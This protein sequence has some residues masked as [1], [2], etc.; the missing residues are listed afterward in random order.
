MPKEAPNSKKK[1]L[2]LIAVVILALVLVA[3]GVRHSIA[4][5][6][7]AETYNNA[8]QLF[9]LGRYTEARQL[10]AGLSSYQDAEARV[11][12][13]DYRS[14][15]KLKDA[16]LY[17]DAAAAFTALGNYADAP[18]MAAACAA[19]LEDR[20][21]ASADA[22]FAAGEYQKALLAYM[23]IGGTGRSAD[24]IR[25]CDYQLT[26]QRLETVTPPEA[27][28]ELETWSGYGDSA[29]R[30]AALQE[31]PYFLRQEYAG[32][33]VHDILT[34]GTYEQDNDLENGPEP[35]EWLVLEDT[36][37]VLTLISRYCLFFQPYDADNNEVT[38]ETCGL[39][40]YLNDEFFTT[41]F[42]SREAGII[43]DT[44]V[45]TPDNRFRKM[46]GGNDTVDKVYVLSY[47]EASTLF[48][49]RLARLCDTT[50]YALTQRGGH[51]PKDY[52]PTRDAWWLRT[53]GWNYQYAVYVHQDGRLVDYD[54]CQVYATCCAVRPVIRINTVG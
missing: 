12:E 26:L 4:P 51:I 21:Y 28:A 49:D 16:E 22:L 50:P 54:S 39:R 47:Q 38:W 43:E 44:S 45:H 34:L 7:N 41:A 46:P 24:G 18:E 23:A 36:D 15:M 40:R 53:T 3:A 8:L 25:A 35:I 30:I 17:T 52:H 2:W 5:D 20:A 13:C 37:G 31:S 27:I 19:A 11:L 10:F 33:T 48:K 1:Y 14:A 9:A 32:Y 29:E 42:T 6:S